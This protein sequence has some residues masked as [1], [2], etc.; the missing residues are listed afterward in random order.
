MVWGARWM[1][2]DLDFSE[3][4]REIIGARIRLPRE[5]VKNKRP[6]GI[7]LTGRLLEIIKRRWAKRLPQCAFIFHRN[8]KR[9]RDF[10][11]HWKRAS[12]A[13]GQPGLWFRRP[14]AGGPPACSSA[15]T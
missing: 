7:P 9:I 5:V 15:T 2:C 6:H 1:Q 4:G 8:G 13:I 14:P 12:E 3:D 11:S 10:R